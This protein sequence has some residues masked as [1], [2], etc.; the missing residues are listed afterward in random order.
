MDIEIDRKIN[1]NAILFLL[2]QNRQQT[3]DWTLI[4]SGA[5]G[6]DIPEYTMHNCKKNIIAIKK[7]RKEKNEFIRNI[8]V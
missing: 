1:V 2:V 5:N 7:K 8:K 3:Q 4:G 6:L